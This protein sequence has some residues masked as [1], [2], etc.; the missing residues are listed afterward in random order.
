MRKRELACPYCG[1]KP[2]ERCVLTLAPELP[3]LSIYWEHRA[4]TERELA[5]VS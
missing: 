4:R 1:A 3:P 5:K 2:G